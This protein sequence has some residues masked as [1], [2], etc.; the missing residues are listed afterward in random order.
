MV[1]APV[2]DIEEKIEE[3]ASVEPEAVEPVAEEK[4]EEPATIEPEVAL[5]VVSTD[6][7]PLPLHSSLFPPLRK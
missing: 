2:P 7:T 6:K 4:V 5:P 1:E 3:R